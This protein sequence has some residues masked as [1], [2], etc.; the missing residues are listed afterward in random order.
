M[1][2]PDVSLAIQGWLLIVGL[3][4]L[5]GVWMLPSIQEAQSQYARKTTLVERIISHK[6]RLT[7]LP[8]TIITI[9]PLQDEDNLTQ[10][11]Q[12]RISTILRANGGR[13]TGL[14]ATGR[15]DTPIPALTWKAG[16]QGDLLAIYD[17][18]KGLQ[19]IEGFTLSEVSLRPARADLNAYSLEFTGL[20]PLIPLSLETTDME[21]TELFL[22][23]N[24]FD[25]ERSAFSR[26]IQ[27]PIN[28]RATAA[29]EPALLGLRK[30]GGIWVASIAPTPGAFA[31]SVNVGDE[32]EFGKILAISANGVEI[33]KPDG[34]RIQLS[35]PFSR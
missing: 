18:L 33:E 1:K 2:R 5:A 30:S 10:M 19:T 20:T 12:Q 8:P 26:N 35:D 27:T 29:A 13:L 31:V 25:R 32:L 6:D 4:L 34:E 9:T 24:P 28:P 17:T 3:T 23:R 11:T 16:A 15:V 21:K 7:A 14:A 22:N